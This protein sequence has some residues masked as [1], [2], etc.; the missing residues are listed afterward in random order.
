MQGLEKYIP[1]SPEAHLV[2]S[3]RVVRV[4][5]EKNGDPTKIILWPWGSA[6]GRLLVTEK[7]L[8][9]RGVTSSNSWAKTGSGS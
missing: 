9:A 7:H 8:T 1:D 4:D 5:P 2:Y 6:T 3:T